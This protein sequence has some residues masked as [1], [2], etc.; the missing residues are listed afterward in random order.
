M[1]EANLLLGVIKP[2]EAEVAVA[3][4]MALMVV[5]GAELEVQIMITVQTVEA[6][7]PMEQMVHQPKMVHIAVVVDK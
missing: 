6:V 5:L 2:Q 3:L 7:E 4:E 1:L